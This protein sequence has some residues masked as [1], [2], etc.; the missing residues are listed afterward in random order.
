MRERI[1]LLEGLSGRPFSSLV[2]EHDDGC[3]AVVLPL[4]VQEHF[5]D[6]DSED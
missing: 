3:R 2:G 5:P 6:A 4:D 1:D